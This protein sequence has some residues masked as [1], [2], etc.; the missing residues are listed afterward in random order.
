VNGAIIPL[1]G[2]EWA[3][4]KTLVVGEVKSRTNQQGEVDVKTQALSYFSRLADAQRFQHLAH[5]VLHRRG[6]ECSSR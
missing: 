1:V 2:V 3:E 6:I 4:V 5:S